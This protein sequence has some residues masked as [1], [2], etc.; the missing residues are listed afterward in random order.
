MQRLANSWDHPPDPVNPRKLVGYLGLVLLVLGG[1][2]ATSLPWAFVD[3]EHTGR[4]VPWA[5]AV[6]ITLLAGAVGLFVGR[7]RG[8]GGSEGSQKD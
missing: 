7:G 4:L 3:A 5:V 1:F 6:A 8:G 2:M